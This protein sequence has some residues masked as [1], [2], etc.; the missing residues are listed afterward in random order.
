MKY[1]NIS[2]RTVLRGM[3]HG[4]AVSVGLPMLDLFLDENGT[5]LADGSSLP[6][7]FGTWFWG[8]GLCPGRWEP[9][10]T[11][12]DYTMAPQ[13][14]LFEP[15]RNKINIFSNMEAFLDGKPHTVHSSSVEAILTGKVPGFNG[16]W[17]GVSFQ[18][19]DN[20]IGE[21]LRVRTR[22]P[23]ITAACDGDATNSYSARGENARVPAEISPVALYQRI[24]G[25]GFKDPNAAEFTPDPMVM[26]DKSALSFVRED[27]KKLEGKVGARDRERLDEF[28]SS[29]RDLEQRLALELERPEPMPAC[30]VP[31]APPT[32]D[33]NFAI[34]NIIRMHDLFSDLMVHALACG[35]TRIFNLSMGTNVV[36]AGDPSSN[37]VYTHQEQDDPELGYQPMV[38]WF[39]EQYMQAF[40]SIVQKLDSVQEGET[41]LLDRTLMMAYTEHGFARW[42]S[43]TG[44]PIFT[45]GGASGGMKNGYH[46]SGNGGTVAQVG[47]TCQ[48]ALGIPVKSWGEDSNRVT[49]PFADVLA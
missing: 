23:A 16:G 35:Q 25:E 24:F 31:D 37:H 11:G 47:F 8:L 27:R 30:T 10:G 2:R 41:T 48:R 3:L 21:Q 26:L 12:R 28:F 5:A 15:I 6:S 42:H 13:L 29:M 36:K 19:L 45:A 18:S 20:L 17:A 7:C 34:H 1:N 4:S 33:S 39:A 46:I 49:E 22:F 43:L 40:V 44:F 32:E 38:H 9:G 14:K